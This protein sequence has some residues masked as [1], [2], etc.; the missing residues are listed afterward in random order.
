MVRLVLGLGADVV[1]REPAELAVAVAQRAYAAV[2]RSSHLPA[3][4]L[5]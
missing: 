4:E 2:H 5:G 1:V 3:G